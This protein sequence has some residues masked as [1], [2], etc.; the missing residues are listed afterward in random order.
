MQV[1][2]LSTRRGFL[3]MSVLGAA[4]T[5][6]LAAC[7]GAPSAPGTPTQVGTVQDT[8]GMTPTPAL[9]PTLTIQAGAAPT[10]VAKKVTVSLWHDWGDKVDEGGAGPNIELCAL[11]EKMYP[12]VKMQNVFDATWDKILTALAGGTPPDTFVLSAEQVPALSD[13]G[14]IIPLDSYMQQD[15]V[16]TKRFFDF[17]NRQCSWAGKYMSITHHPDIR[18]LWSDV[19]VFKDAGLD[20]AKPAKTWDEMVTYAKQMTK[21]EGNRFAVMGW[22]PSWTSSPWIPQYVQINGGKLLSEDGK[23]ATFASPEGI[24]AVEFMLKTTEDLYGGFSAVAEFQQ[25]NAFPQG[26]GTY[27]GF[28][29]HILGM[30]FYGNWLADAIEMDNRSMELTT[31]TFPGGPAQA[32]KE[33]IV[34]GGTMCAIPTGAKEKD[35][36]WK[37]LLLLASDDGGYIVQRLGNDLSGII[38]AAEDPRIV[39]NKLNR[40]KILAMLKKANI[41]HYAE[42]PVSDKF[43]AL[44][45]RTGEAILLKQGTAKDLLTKAQEEAQKEL[46]DYYSKKK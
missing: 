5:A 7:G 4:G 16:D 28:P 8:K 17:V 42:S 40:D 23:K 35:W 30:A 14:A 37:F 11:M 25:S 43:A 20:P 24:A 1:R 6:F 33:F 19:K 41:L 29:H 18:L 34:S 22:V 2:K 32:G 39:Q 38:K 27:G 46:D 12:E 44:F 36:A 3:K 26:T 9:V 21:K 10:G 13:R 45:T 31:G 15:K